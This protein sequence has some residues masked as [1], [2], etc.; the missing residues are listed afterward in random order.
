MGIFDGLKFGQAHYPVPVGIEK[1]LSQVTPLSAEQL[2]AVE[3][4]PKAT[5]EKFQWE[6]LKGL[7]GQVGFMEGERERVYNDAY[8]AWADSGYNVTTMQTKYPEKWAAFTQFFGTTDAYN[9]ILDYNEKAVEEFKQKFGTLPATTPNIYAGTTVVERKDK[10]G[11][12]VLS[13]V[14]AQNVEDWERSTV[15]QP[16]NISR[17]KY[18]VPTVGKIQTPAIPNTGLL[19]ST[20][21]SINKG[22]TSYGSQGIDAKKPVAIGEDIY[23]RSGG[24]FTKHNATQLNSA[25]EQFIT[26]VSSNPQVESQMKIEFMNS[27]NNGMVPNVIEKQEVV[28]D[29]NGKTLKDA[30]GKDVIRKYLDVDYIDV[31]KYT[32]E[33]LKDLY[34]KYTKETDKTKKDKLLNDINI[35][36]N[37][38]SGDLYSKYVSTRAY[39]FAQPNMISETTSN[40]DL[41][42]IKDGSSGNG[43]GSKKEIKITPI[44]AAEQGALSKENKQL[45]TITDPNS[46]TI[47]NINSTGEGRLLPRHTS[48]LLPYQTKLKTA[49]W[50]PYLETSE[51]AMNNTVENTFIGSNIKGFQNIVVAGKE[52]DGK[53]LKGGLIYDVVGILTANDENRTPKRWIAVD[54]VTGKLGAGNV[55]IPKSNN[56][57]IIY[58]TVDIDEAFEN[59]NTNELA[60]LGIEII[61]DERYMIGADADEDA[62]LENTLHKKLGGN[63]DIRSRTSFR[64]EKTL[65]DMNKNGVFKDGITVTRNGEDNAYKITTDIADDKLMKIRVLIPYEVVENMKEETSKDPSYMKNSPSEKYESTSNIEEGSIN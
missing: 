19:Q 57:K 37:K 32:T 44:T 53:L 1:P 36:Q 64:A 42:K 48:Q 30:K 55:K 65:N 34:D 18:G 17:G 6:K 3:T 13:I 2:I 63:M 62:F 10:D 11:K 61:D 47:D 41:K 16:V 54:V 29:A 46:I 28:K 14:P 5:E 39:L 21:N 8:N 22:Y 60:A 49:E 20:W 27:L 38:I 24:T 35:A 7:P 45:I 33:Q 15:E 52:M 56:G 58:E 31:S 43:N 4:K 9:E 59:G 12:E 26:E 51:W 40:L 25:R 50:A 23:L